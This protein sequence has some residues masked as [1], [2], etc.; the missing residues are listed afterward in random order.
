MMGPMVAA[1]DSATTSNQGQNLLGEGHGDT[2]SGEPIT[3]SPTRPTVDRR[4]EVYVL[5]IEG[6]PLQAWRKDPPRAGGCL[7]QGVFTRQETLG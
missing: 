2:V 3:A 4:A 7:A 5:N 1:A 6:R